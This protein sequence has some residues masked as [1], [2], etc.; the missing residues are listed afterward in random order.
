MW[1]QRPKEE[2]E[3]KRERREEVTQYFHT[4]PEFFAA[5]F[6]LSYRSWLHSPSGPS[7]GSPF[8]RHSVVP[9][10]GIIITLSGPLFKNTEVRELDVCRATVSGNKTK[11]TEQ[12]KTKSRQTDGQRER[13]Q[14]ERAGRSTS[15]PSVIFLAW[16][17][18]NLVHRICNEPLLFVTD[19]ATDIAPP[20]PRCLHLFGRNECR[21]NGEN[22]GG[23]GRCGG[24]ELHCG[25]RWKKRVLGVFW[26]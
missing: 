5:N 23:G 18:V 20:P 19:I 22:S 11:H 9:A 1:A 14:R 12:S 15:C 7:R 26:N 8:G 24:A 16:D 6:T 25:E 21:S 13:R 3:R 2:R 10:H 4:V 17:R